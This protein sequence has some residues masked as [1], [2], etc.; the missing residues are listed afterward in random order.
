MTSM[1]MSPAPSQNTDRRVI[2]DG[3][4]NTCVYLYSGR[5]SWDAG[6]PYVILIADGCTV[7]L[8]EPGCTVEI[9]DHD[10]TVD[11][12]A[13]DDIAELIRIAD[14]CRE[15]NEREARIA[16]EDWDHR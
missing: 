2:V 13:D 7:E 5:E 6:N 3:D 11:S 15:E 12:D 4:G 14:E 1:T 9:N 8:R 10:I 16:A